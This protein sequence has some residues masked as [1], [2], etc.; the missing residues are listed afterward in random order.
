MRKIRHVKERKKTAH[1]A[2]ETEAKSN[3]E[4]TSNNNDTEIEASNGNKGQQYKEQEQIRESSKNNVMEQEANDDLEIGS[5]H[6][7]TVEKET[8]KVI[9][10]NDVDNESDMEE[11]RNAPDD[12]P[13]EIEG[14]DCFITPS[15]DG[16]KA[17]HNSE[18]VSP[19]CDSEYDGPKEITVA[20]SVH[21]QDESTEELVHDSETDIEIDESSGNESEVNEKFGNDSN[22]FECQWNV[23][24]EK[25]GKITLTKDKL[26]QEKRKEMK[27]AE[28]DHASKKKKL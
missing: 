23:N 14:N 7:A 18:N 5:A 6:E 24:L 16:S 10:S 9:N 26:S 12:V 25:V 11:I 17:S 2:K 28:I 3:M 4:K 20:A 22:P 15:Q 1:V 13:K 21:R 27:N 8:V 19:S